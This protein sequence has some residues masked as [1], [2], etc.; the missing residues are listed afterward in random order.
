VSGAVYTADESHWDFIAEVMKHCI[1]TNPLHMDEFMYVTQCEAEIL[2]WTLDLYNGDKDT[3]GM[4]TSGGTESIFQCVLAYREL[5]KEEK[6]ITRPNIVMAETGHPAFDKACFYLKIELRKVP[7][8]KEF[9]VNL[10]GMKQLIDSNTILLVASAPD[11]AYGLY[12]PVPQIA[13]LAASYGIGCHSDCCLGSYIN[14]FAD[15]L[16]YKLPC[17]FDFRVPGVTSISVDPHKYAYGPKGCSLALFRH[18]T[19]RNSA[20][21]VSSQW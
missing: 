6:G 11:Y 5:Y 20:L 18:K 17:A 9:K 14:P 19:L 21:F 12:E 8:T 15:E 10:Y 16:G 1:V 4:V 13:A 7:M 3:C 2:R